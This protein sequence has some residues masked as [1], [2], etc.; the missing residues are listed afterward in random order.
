MV[1][2]IIPA[3]TFYVDENSLERGPLSREQFA[4]IQHVKRRGEQL[5]RDHPE[6]A[7]LYRDRGK[8]LVA[9]DIAQHYFS[10][11]HLRFK[12]NQGAVSYALRILIG[13]EELAELNCEKRVKSLE[14]LFPQGFNSEQFREHCRRASLLRHQSG[15]GVDA[16]AMTRGRGFTPWTREERTYA[17]TH[18]N[19]QTNNYI[20]IARQLNALFHD[21]KELRSPK[22][23][24]DMIRYETRRKNSNV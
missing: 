9:R 16:T 24:Y 14:A 23:T 10:D 15:I 19:P 5:A 2:L 7:D 18:Y 12:V 8:N 22:S 21:G 11:N 20:E 6:I 1:A 4:A 3:G 13:P 17:K